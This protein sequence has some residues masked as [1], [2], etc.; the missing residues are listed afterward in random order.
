MRL[1]GVSRPLALRLLGFSVVSFPLESPRWGTGGGFG[2]TFAR[3]INGKR[4]RIVLLCDEVAVWQISN[5][6]RFNLLLSIQGM[7]ALLRVE[8]SQAGL[9][10]LLQPSVELSECYSGYQETLFEDVRVFNV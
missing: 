5:C 6:G 7:G 2:F 10:T 1:L 3:E 8:N 4:W 9:A